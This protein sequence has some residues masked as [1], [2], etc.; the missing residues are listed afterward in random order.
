MFQ[1]KKWQMQGLRP[2]DGV[3]YCLKQIVKQLYKLLIVIQ[4]QYR[5]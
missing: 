4:E 2:E 1:N 3:T 5:V